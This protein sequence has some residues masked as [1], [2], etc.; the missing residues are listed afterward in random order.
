[1]RATAQVKDTYLSNWTVM[2][3]YKESGVVTCALQPCS[4]R[5]IT[6]V[7]WAP[8]K[9]SM[10]RYGDRGFLILLCHKHF[11]EQRNDM[12]IITRFVEDVA[13]PY[14]KYRDM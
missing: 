6:L 8:D 3:Q 1:M 2:C 4:H 5:P 9:E 11:E 12:N 13:K 7:V 14:R 10:N